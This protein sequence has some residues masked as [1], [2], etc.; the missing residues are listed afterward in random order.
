MRR[1]I[2]PQS[3]KAPNS[4]QGAKAQ[5]GNRGSA[6]RYVLPIRRLHGAAVKSPISAGRWSA[7][8]P[9]A[10]VARTEAFVRAGPCSGK[11]RRHD[12]GMARASCRERVESAEVVGASEE[13]RV[14]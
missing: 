9:A 10:A 5:I 14:V 7:N 1:F 8:E 13:Q 6:A 11:R 12:R 2:P 3:K 4:R